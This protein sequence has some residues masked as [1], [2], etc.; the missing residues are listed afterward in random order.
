MQVI[1]KIQTMFAV[2]TLAVSCNSAPPKTSGK[3]A[4]KENSKPEPPAKSFADNWEFKG[5]AVSE[6][7]WHV[8]G[9]SPIV[10]PKGKVHLFVSRWPLKTGHQGW[11]SHSQIAHYIGE[12]PEG[13]FKFSDVALKGTGTDTC[14]KHAP[15]NPAIHKVD[16]WDK[17]APH[18]GTIHKVKNQYVLLYIGNN[19][20]DRSAHPRNQRIGMAT[21]SSLNG[22]WKKVGKDG[23]ILAPPN[24]RAFYNY[25][26]ANGVNNPALLQKDGKFFLYF[27]SNDTRKDLKWRP[28]MGLA[29]ADKV[30]GPY[31]QLKTPVTDNNKVIE[32]EYAFIYNG[33][34]ALLTTD[35]HGTIEKGGGILWTSADGILFDKF[36]KGF[37]R[38]SDYTKVDHAKKV[39]TQGP[40]DYNKGER[41]QVLLIDGKPKYLYMSSGT[42]IYGKHKGSISYVLKCKEK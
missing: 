31:I 40:R 2:A 30:E 3:D 13:P 23:M 26:A 41:P 33:K 8:W 39:V 12:S 18:N 19:N 27:K 14:D 4:V 17:F 42:N 10:G 25:Q 34:V 29:I 20:P 7:G 5:T 38:I 11:R 37:H 21:S 28:K 36:E 9:S 6:P 15:C 1:S 35:N 22:P 24:D 32:D 16:T